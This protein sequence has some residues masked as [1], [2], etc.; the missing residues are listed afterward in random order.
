MMDLFT[1]CLIKRRK[2]FKEYAIICPLI[3]VGVILSLFYYIFLSASILSG[4]GLAAVVLIW[5]GIYLLISNYN[6]EF[7][8]IITNGDIDIDVI[9]SRRKRKRLASFSLKDV[10]IIAPINKLGDETFDNVIDA[11]A[12]DKRYDVYYISANIKGQKTKIL[13]NP[14][15]KM[16]NIVK[17]LNA[18]KVITNE[19]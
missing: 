1:E 12:H 2:H 7:E 10:E 11:S 17:E 9:F 14:S 18:K 16:L 13:L 4:V 8:Y 6:L 15:E 5:W 19:E 3:T